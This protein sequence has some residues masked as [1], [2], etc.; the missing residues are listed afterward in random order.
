[1]YAKLVNCMHNPKG[2]ISL[3]DIESAV[4]YFV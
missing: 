1:M 3:Q 4:L 2:D